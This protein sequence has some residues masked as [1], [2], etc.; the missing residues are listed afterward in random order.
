MAISV[1]INSFN[2]GE[3]TPYL[4]G[5]ED[6]DKYGSGCKTLTNLVPIPY[7]GVRKRRGFAYVAPAKYDD[8]PCR[9]VRFQF[10]MNETF[11]LEFGEGYI[12]F[13]K[14]QA[15]VT[16]TGEDGRVPYEVATPYTAAEVFELQW[17]QSLD[18]IFLAH[19]N[20]PPCKL[21]RYGDTDWRFAQIDFMQPPFLE[22]NEEEIWLHLEEHSATHAIRLISD[23]D[24][25]Q[26]GHAGACF[27]LEHA[28]SDVS[29]VG[30]VGTS[31]GVPVR[32]SW[33]LG[34][35]GTWSGVLYIERSYDREEKGSDADATW[36]SYR[37]Y[38]SSS[39]RNID[40]AG[41]EDDACHLRVRTSEGFSVTETFRWELNLTEYYRRGIVR[42]TQVEHARS[43]VVEI[44]QK[45]LAYTAVKRWY[46]GAWSA[47]RGFPKAAT[48]Y[49][50]RLFF[51]GSR[52]EPQ[53]IWA[54]QVNDYENFEMGTLDTD[55]L[56]Y[57]FASEARDS[58]CWIAAL[59]DI[60]VGTTGGEWRISASETKDPLTPTNVKIVRQS[61]YGSGTL[62]AEVVNDVV[63]FPQRENRRLRELKY[64]LQK[65]GYAAEDITLL[66]EHITGEGVVD[67]AFQQYPEAVLWCV[68]KDGCLASLTYDNDNAVRA[69]SRHETQGKF[70]SVETIASSVG[71]ELWAA[72]ERTLPSGKRIYIERMQNENSLENTFRER[73]ERTFTD[74]ASVQLCFLLDDTGSM[75]G[76]IDAMK[77]QMVSIAEG[78]ETVYPGKITYALLTFK[79]AD[80]P[81]QVLDFGAFAPFNALLDT[82]VAEGG[83]DTEEDAYG[84]IVKAAQDLSWSDS[85]NALRL[86]IL[87]TDA[88]S[89]ENGATKAQAAAAV[90]G[91]SCRFFYIANGLSAWADF[92][93]AV[94]GLV[95]ESMEK[96][97][98]T[99]LSTLSEG[100]LSATAR[101]V[102]FLDSAVSYQGLVD[103]TQMGGLE[104]L[105]G[106]TVAV[107]ANGG[108]E[109]TRTVQDG[110]ISL[111][112]PAYDVHAGLPYTAELE[113]LCINGQGPA[114]STQNMVRRIVGTSLRLHRSG[115][116]KVGTSDGA[117]DPVSFRD[118]ADPTDAPAPLFTGVIHKNFASSTAREQG[119]VVRSDEPEPL[120]LL[121]LM[122]EIDA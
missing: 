3:F 27:A 74:F 106:L 101:E 76:V 7:G 10:A 26:S 45:P 5:R 99:V 104:H 117:L 88:P 107:V 32:G 67:A 71:D 84:A 8:K 24:L 109:G 95:F 30:G 48:F 46:E 119:V 12:R 96:L 83:G 40:V 36:E 92:A 58:I 60:A 70:R 4:H 81:K 34:T 53:T 6:Y 37:A 21:S 16:V 91:L 118:S 49:Q 1:E 23:T 54:S 29:T 77:T 63:I 15:P 66:S 87:V 105:E 112:G 97:T 2:A 78:L 79:D 93:D 82:V 94:E 22:R 55:A 111:L 113:T 100:T 103:I 41:D 13:F 102:D 31:A 122:I 120:T 50:R 72:V 52:H 108:Y 114:G 110:K 80:E 61:T 89:H 98:N 33:N 38:S 51:G 62:A 18:V 115:A 11:M 75:S 44:L 42:V 68:R 90:E 28:R 59:E 121:C 57:A 20:H 73:T 116:C 35:S 86:M 47:V 19:E 17:V 65:D 9:L 14:N 39:D 85:E 69:W 43:A 56:T 25:F 64:S